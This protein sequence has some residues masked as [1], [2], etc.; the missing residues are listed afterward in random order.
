MSAQVVAWP[1]TAAP[2]MDTPGRWVCVPD[3]AEELTGFGGNDDEAT[4]DMLDQFD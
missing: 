2:V 3:D 4:D 1:C